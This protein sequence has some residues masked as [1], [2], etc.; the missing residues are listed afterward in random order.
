MGRRRI[1]H[2]LG[3]H[4]G[5]GVPN[6]KSYKMTTHL[7]KTSNDNSMGRDKIVNDNDFTSN[8]ECGIILGTHEEVIPSININCLQLV[9]WGSVV[10]DITPL[11]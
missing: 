5:A 3:A 4:N 1:Q 8:S 9:N 11:I 6:N 7:A 2:F 10:V